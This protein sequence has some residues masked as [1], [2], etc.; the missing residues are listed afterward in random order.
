MCFGFL[1]HGSLHRLRN[2]HVLDLHPIHSDAPRLCDL[3]DDLT[4]HL[5]EL[6]LF[7]HQLIERVLSYDAAQ[8]RESGLPHGIV[9]E[10]DLDDRLFR[11]YNLVPDDSLDLDR[12]VIVGHG[13]LRLNV[14][15][16]HANIHKEQSIDERDD[17]GEAWLPGATIATEAESE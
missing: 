12:Y 1:G 3:V 15:R 9:I 4:E 14:P 7:L 17:P 2:F 16:N 8:C 6:V 11:I 10:P 13:L 5:R